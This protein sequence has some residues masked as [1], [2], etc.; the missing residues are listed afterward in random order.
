MAGAIAGS[1]HGPSRS[2]RT[3]VRSYL[4]LSRWLYQTVLQRG[5]PS[6]AVPAGSPR[7]TLRSLSFPN[8]YSHQITQSY[9]LLEFVS[10]VRL[11][12]GSVAGRM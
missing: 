7:A 6:D 8:A 1:V 12:A 5:T 3:L 2:K 9:Q 11:Q 10:A 4:R